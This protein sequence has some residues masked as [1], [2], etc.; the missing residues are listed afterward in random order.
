MYNIMM[1]REYARRLTGQ[2][3]DCFACQPGEP[4]SGMAPRTDSCM[5]ECITQAL[6]AVK[7]STV[8][9]GDW[10]LAHSRGSG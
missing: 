2:G 6:L 8:H 10:C 3:V 4:D 9:A 7:S 1:A 5:L